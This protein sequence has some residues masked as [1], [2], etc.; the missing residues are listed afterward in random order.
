[1]PLKRP[2]VRVETLILGVAIYFI[3]FANGSWWRA[4]AQGRELH[5]GQTWLFFAACF[6]A[7]AAVHY[8]LLALV[9]NR[10][11]V[12]PVLVVLVI[13]TAFAS[14]YMST[15]HVLLDPT[16]LQNVLATDAHET[17]ELLSLSM[18]GYVIA[19]SA[20]PIACIMWVQ[21]QQRPLWHAL[22]FRVATVAI[23]L[24][25]AAGAL[26]PVNRDFTSLMR[27]QRELRYLATPGNFVYSLARTVASDVA[28]DAG[29]KQVVGADAHF[30]PKL[31][32]RQRP[33]VFVFVLGETARAEDFSLFGYGRD[34][35]PE[36][37][38]LDVVKFDRVTSC[39]TSTEVSVPCIFSP[40]GR[41][42]YDEQ[43]IRHSEGLLHV[44]RRAGFAV[45]WRE[46]QSGCKGVCDAP[47][48][49]YQQL[50][51]T[52]APDLCADGEC[53]DEILVRSLERDL[54]TIAGNTV[55]VLHMMGNH[56]PA[57]YKRYPEAFRRFTPDC[58]TAELREC[59]REEVVNAFDNVILYTDHVLSEI[60]RVLD[61]A[62]D[63]FDTAMLY[64]SDHGESLGEGGL[65][66]HGIPYAI[67]PDHQTHVP[68][69]AW[70]S[71]PFAQAAGID[72]RCLRVRADE[73]LSHDNIFHSLLGVLDVETNIYRAERDL[74]L[75]CR[76]GP[77]TP[78]TTVV[79]R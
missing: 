79:G 4:L 65:Y 30:V 56:G 29:P 54:K 19:W 17:R 5:S 8:V 73:T 16:M 72:P 2:T 27:N 75:P 77:D 76:R 26:L 71:Q 33:T 55:I 41:A 9:A 7:L 23:A 10:W 43:L 18:V 66:L 70:M 12:K 60:I 34:T 69:I 39:G 63:R 31:A 6:V 48:I 38:R 15:Y 25:V 13:A 24:V 67:A 62:D 21:L 50:D 1:M 14:Y 20:P 74:F 68:M 64:V 57:Y 35:N 49:D 40:Y 51:A 37:A 59:S 32:T 46:N 61:K 44:L 36:L 53:H 52:L 47:G 45:R 22:G 28:A 58:R 42:D 3:A 11:T 78:A